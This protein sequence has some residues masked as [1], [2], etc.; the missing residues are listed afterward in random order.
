MYVTNT[1]HIF[2]LILQSAFVSYF[3]DKQLDAIYDLSV[4]YPGTLPQNEFDV[5]RGKFPEEVHF[6]IKR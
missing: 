6:H 3:T 5:L 2:L 4:G 1:V